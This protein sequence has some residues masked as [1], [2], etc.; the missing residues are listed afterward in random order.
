MTKYNCYSE[1]FP[2]IPFSEDEICP[3]LAERIKEVYK[4]YNRCHCCKCCENCCRR[5]CNCVNYYHFGDNIFNI[6]CCKKPKTDI[7]AFNQE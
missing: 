2:N 6:K 4:N 7:P 5:C 1:C 3:K